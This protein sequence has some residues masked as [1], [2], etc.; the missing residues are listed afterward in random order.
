M[1]RF[2]LLILICLFTPPSFASETLDMSTFKKLPVLDNGRVKPLSVFAKQHMEDFH[3]KSKHAD[4]WI[5]ETLF[6]PSNALETKIFEIK[7]D[8]LKGKLGVPLDQDHFNIIELESGLNATKEDVA[9]LFQKDQDSLL[10]AEKSLLEIHEKVITYTELLRTFSLILPLQD[11]TNFYQKLPEE[12]H[13]IRDLKKIVAQ[14][15]E[16]FQNYNENEQNI[17]RIGFE[18]QTIRQGG[19]NNNDFKI[20]PRKNSQELDWIAPWQ[21]INEG[22]GSPATSEFLKLWQNASTAYRNQDNEK[23]Q[24]TTNILLQKTLEEGAPKANLARLKIEQIYQIIKPYNITMIL[25]AVS[26]GFFLITFRTGRFTLAAIITA[27]SGLILHTFAI[28]ARI[29]IL[30]RPPVGT[31][32]ESVIFVSLICAAFSLLFYKTQKMEKRNTIIPITGQSAALILLAIAPSALQGNDSLELLVAVLNT[33]FWLGTHVIVIT[34]GYAACIL[35]A[36]LSHAYMI[37]RAQNT[38][39]NAAQKSYANLFEIIHKTSLVALLLTAV[40]TVLGGIWADQSWGRF[41]GWDPKENGALL[42]VLWLIW[43]QHGRLSGHIRPLAYIAGMAALNIITALAWFGVNLLGVGLH[44]YGFTS[45]IAS[46][47]AFFCIVETLIIL[48]LWV[49]IRKKENVKIKGAKA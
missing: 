2:F 10:K 29:Y 23:W 11:G 43:L 32:Y 3:G 39:S 14:K 37:L 31:L 30:D 36:C 49:V 13:I 44:S 20:I 33:N 40:G 48:S 34:M 12:Q 27:I 4:R 47:L 24:E 5:A 17:A 22:K 25:Y 21:I 6:N 8:I 18:I 26:I 42:I 28:L 16:D 41:W 35:C 7:S 19:A 46:G 15:G 45:G 1:I 38:S 9:R